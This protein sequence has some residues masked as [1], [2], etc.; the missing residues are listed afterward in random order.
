LDSVYLDTIAI[1]PVGSLED[2]FVAQ[3]FA[4]IIVLDNNPASYHRKVWRVFR[5]VA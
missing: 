5:R 1:N 2:N 3:C 4:A